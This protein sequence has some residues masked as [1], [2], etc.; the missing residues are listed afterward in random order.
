MSNR[1]SEKNELF[2]CLGILLGPL[3]HLVANSDSYTTQERTAVIARY[4]ADYPKLTQKFEVFSKGQPGHDYAVENIRFY[5]AL[6]GIRTQLVNDA[7]LED[8]LP[9]FAK[10]AISAIDSIPVPPIS[11]I[12]AAGTPFS[13]YCK[14]CELCEAEVTNELTWIDAYLDSSIFHRY[15]SKV[16]DSVR[17]TVVIEALNQSASSREKARWNSFL[18]VSRVFAN[19]YG[20][21]RYNLYVANS[22]HDRWVVIDRNRIYSFGGS[23][24]DAARKD[25]FTLSYVEPSPENLKIIDDTIIQAAEYFGANTVN[26][27]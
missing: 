10:K 12:H 5:K 26:H 7:K 13:T 23:A 15:L 19:E 6:N 16:R 14:I 9:G 4:N 11:V 22:L 1:L 24:K 8:I 20:H 18:D 3:E 27:L 2:Y 21:T 25:H 17:I